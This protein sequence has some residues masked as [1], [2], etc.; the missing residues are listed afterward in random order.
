APW[1]NGRI[2]FDN[3]PLGAALAEFERYGDTGFIVRDPAVARLRIG[4]SFSLAQLDRFAAALPQ[5]LPVHVVHDG[6]ASEI[7]MAA[8]MPAQAPAMHL[9]QN[10]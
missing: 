6:A 9:Q 2:T 8:R 7:R 5:L 1:R 10:K 4:G 3:V